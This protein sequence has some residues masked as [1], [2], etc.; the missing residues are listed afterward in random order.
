MYKGIRIILAI[1]FFR[2]TAAKGGVAKFQ[3]T[4]LLRGIIIN[5]TTKFESSKPHSLCDKDVHT[6]SYIESC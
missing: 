1:N 4:I 5:I 3:N 2:F 6:D